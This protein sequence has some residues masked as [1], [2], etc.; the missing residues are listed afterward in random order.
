VRQE[1]TSTTGHSQACAA[2]PQAPPAINLSSTAMPDSGFETGDRR[3]PGAGGHHPPPD[4]PSLTAL[5]NESLIWVITAGRILG[6]S[7][8]PTVTGGGRFGGQGY[9]V[10]PTV[11]TNT[12]PDMKIVREEIF[13][14]VVVAEPFRSLDEI[15]AEANRSDPLGP[16]GAMDQLPPDRPH[17]T[18]VATSTQHP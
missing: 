12:R 13:G 6:V 7:L 17:T 1:R 8:R 15:A 16:I 5:A 3:V 18:L 11:I 9:F 10:E 14:P 4:R 2:R